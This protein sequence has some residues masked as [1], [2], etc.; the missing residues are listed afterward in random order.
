M[1]FQINVFRQRNIF[2][3]KLQNN[4]AYDSIFVVV[5]FE[6]YRKTEV[7]EFN[8]KII[9]NRIYDLQTNCHNRF[10]SR[11][12]DAPNLQRRSMI[13]FCFRII[14]FR[15]VRPPDNVFEIHK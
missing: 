14:I 8:K 7:I 1:Y 3:A 2:T 10:K 15:Y 6:H 9:Q 12:F 4:L 13:V 11:S 5:N